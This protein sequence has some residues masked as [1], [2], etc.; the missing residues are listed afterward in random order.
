M[1]VTEVLLCQARERPDAPAIIETKNGRDQII[2]F[3]QLDEASARA[4]QLLKASGLRMGD[5]VLIFQPMSIELYVA[6]LA[7]FRLGLV[8]TFLDPSS[9]RAHLERC[10]EM[11]P[12]K[13]FIASTKAHLLRLTSAAIRKI[14]RK[15]VIGW[16]LPGAIA[17]SSACKEL[18]FDPITPCDPGTPALVT[19]TSGSTGM[20]KAALR[21]HEFL[22]AQHRVL[23]K[24]ITLLPGEIDLTT[25]PIF[26]L[27][28]LGSGVTSL[29]PDADLRRPG[30]VDPKP[31]FAQ[32]ARH[33]PTRTAA[34]PAFL[35]RLAEGAEPGALRYFTK[36]F[37]GGAPVFHPLLR[38]LQTLAPAAEVVAVFGST[39]AE[40]IAHAA[41]GD[42]GTD[43][44][45]A[46]GNGSGLLAGT[47]V[48]EIAVRI[49]P[50]RWGTPL[51]PFSKTD[52]D[53]T[54]VRTGEWGEIVVSGAHVLGGYLNGTGNKE[55][56]IRV[57]DVTWHR[58]GDAGRF[59][60]KGRLWLLGRCAA[61][62]EDKKGLLYPF[63]VECAA[64]SSVYPRRC[65]TLSVNGKRILVVESAPALSAV[66]QRALID[67]LAW[68]G[69][70]EIKFVKTI[71]VDKRHNAKVLYEELRASL[72]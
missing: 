26:V 53:A 18:P 40:P 20:P 58:T 37:T 60:E 42:L 19:F 29:I 32:I 51:G 21:T 47:P 12:P 55:T 3:A 68:A 69:L 41:W 27:A 25:L 50:D 13:A 14:P 2:T 67:S 44:L 62:I 30:A 8:A 45:D 71:P 46:I 63:T 64:Q 36:I 52:F 61:K 49:V 70:D 7:I 54:R 35:H 33:Q 31:I 43:E 72:S 57:E 10:C 9:G 38:Q 22:L 11:V 6:L 15:Y 48:S 23:E 65:A 39:E 28:N 56:K 17:W 4:A 16:S 59:D 34:S 1:N 5:A 66:E 24:N